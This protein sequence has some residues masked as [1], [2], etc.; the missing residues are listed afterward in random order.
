MA[1]LSFT[2]KDSDLWS[3]S[4]GGAGEHKIC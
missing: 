1:N 2:I 4:V 3:G